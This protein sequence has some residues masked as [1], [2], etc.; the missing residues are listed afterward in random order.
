[1]NTIER[2]NRIGTIVQALKEC[3]EK[4][5][6]VNKEELLLYIMEKYNCMRRSALEYFKVAEL[7]FKNGKG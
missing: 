5:L 7:R 1:M 2:A 6:E 4:E 3:K